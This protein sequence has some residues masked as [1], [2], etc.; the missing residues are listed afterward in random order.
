MQSLREKLLKAGLISEDQRDAQ[1]DAA[2]G[3]NRSA[4]RNAPAEGGYRHAQGEGRPRSEHGRALVR[5][6]R[7][8]HER[9]PRS[10]PRLEQESPT[11]S[12]PIPKLPPLS[13]PNNKEL[14]RLEAKKQLELERR[15][16]ELVASTELAVRPGDQT[17]YFVTRKNRL[18]RIEL[19]PELAR[20]LEAGELAVVERPEP[21]RI[22]HSLVPASTADRILELSTRAV[23]FYNR[24]DAPVGFLSDEELSRRQRAEEDRASAPE[25]LFIAP[26]EATGFGDPFTASE[27]QLLAAAA[28]RVAALS[29]SAE[30]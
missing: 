16:R 8:E 21:D 2:R 28:E 7:S 24:K 26:E 12:V 19:T 30:D 10:A 3:R 14:Q 9:R 27:T 22:E 18:R 23:R 4:Q 11:R 29:S 17:F 13:V 6:T 1:T 20:K 5:E 25:P 15:I